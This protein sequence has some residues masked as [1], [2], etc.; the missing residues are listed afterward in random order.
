MLI[1]IQ[2]NIREWKN[3]G[4]LNLGGM[5]GKKIG[6]GSIEGPRAVQRSVAAVNPAERNTGTIDR[7]SDLFTKYQNSLVWNTAF[8]FIVEL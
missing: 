6:T 1:N 7:N 8:I 5:G 3:I 2:E 4:N